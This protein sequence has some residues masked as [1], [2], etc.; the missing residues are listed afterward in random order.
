VYACARAI[1]KQALLTR[2]HE[3]IVGR[4]N[5]MHYIQGF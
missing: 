4:A 1:R 2:R 5:V 3:G